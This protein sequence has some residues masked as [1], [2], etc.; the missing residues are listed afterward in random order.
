MVRVAIAFL[1]FVL[2]P[3]VAQ[4]E[5]RIA[6]VVGIDKYEQSRATATTPTCRQRCAIR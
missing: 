6:F 1:L 3:S 5:K 4:A 2:L